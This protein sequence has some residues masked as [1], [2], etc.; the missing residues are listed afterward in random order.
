MKIAYIPKYWLYFK[1]G[2]TNL[3]D[4]NKYL[5][6]NHALFLISGCFISVNRL[7]FDY[8]SPDGTYN[9]P[10]SQ[11]IQTSQLYLKMFPIRK[12]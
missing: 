10:D 6:C 8:D 12:A 2:I 1:I 3:A 5:V 11:I 9:Y 4:V 7:C